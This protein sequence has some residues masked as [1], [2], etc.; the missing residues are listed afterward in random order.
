MLYRLI[1]EDGYF[2]KDVLLDK[3]PTVSELQ[4][5]EEGNEEVV[6]LPDPKFVKAKPEGLHKP[7]W[8]GEAW[9]EGKT[10]QELEEIANIPIE[11]TDKQVLDDLVALLVEKGIV[12]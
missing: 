12:Y 10:P 7:R 8:N 1:D 11:P 2:I 6:Y 3:A 9:E 4:T 5:D